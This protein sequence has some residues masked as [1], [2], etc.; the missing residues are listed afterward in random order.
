MLAVQPAL[1]TLENRVPKGH[2]GIPHLAKPRKGEHILNAPA[3]TY[4]R[5]LRR[6]LGFDPEWD[7]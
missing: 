3:D 1:V 5:G 2:I 4:A 7:I 6:T